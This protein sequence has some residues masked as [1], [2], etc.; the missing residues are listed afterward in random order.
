MF[1]VNLVEVGV[2]G[3]A[4]EQRVN[5]RQHMDPVFGQF[6]EHR[7]HV[8]WI[9]YQNQLA[10]QAHG[11]HHADREGED[12]VQRQGADQVDLLAGRDLLQ[13][14][15]EPGL[16]LQQIGHQIALQ[17]HC[18]LGYAGGA[19]GVLQHG[20]IVGLEG[21]FAQRSAAAL[22][23]RCIEGHSAGQRERWHQLF[24]VAHH[25]VHQGAFDQ[26]QAVA[27]GTQ[28]HVLDGRGRDALLKH[29]SKILQNH[30]RL[31]ARV[32]ELVLQLTRRVERIDIDQGV[33]RT[34][35]GA[36]RNRVL[37]D[38]GHHHRHS[39]P[40]G[41]SEALQIDRKSLA[42]AVNLRVS[43]L[44]AHEAVGAAV[45]ELLEALLHHR[46]HRRVLPR[47]DVGGDTL[48]IT[49]EPDTFSHACLLIG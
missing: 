17:Q 49:R 32:L 2:I 26:T 45:G 24:L 35:D 30:D 10:A 20:H 18:P 34:Q 13:G 33:A 7:H 19:T 37:Q 48:R 9:G 42:L 16:S 25:V 15:L 11:H 28:H 4:V 41:Q 5:R 12:V 38:V 43:L 47:V 6:T 14:W 27:H 46:H 29:R 21:H 3:H 39:V 40:P 8:A 31:G 22:G 23:K 44:L 36:D 1:P